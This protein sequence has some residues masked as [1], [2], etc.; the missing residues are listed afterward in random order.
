MEILY[1][2]PRSIQRSPLN[3]NKRTKSLSN[4]WCWNY[5]LV[6]F[7]VSYTLDPFDDDSLSTDLSIA[8][9][10]LIFTSGKSR[11]GDGFW[12]RVGIEPTYPAKSGTDRI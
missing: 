8:A 10:T 2:I 3:H 11:F 4:L 6:D 5:Y 12:E 7:V 1:I 9:A